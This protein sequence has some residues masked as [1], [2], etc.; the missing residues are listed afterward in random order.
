MAD[1][2][3]FKKANGYHDANAIIAMHISLPLPFYSTGC[4]FR[5]KMFCQLHV[6]TFC[7]IIL[8]F[9]GRFSRRFNVCNKKTFDV[10]I[11]LKI[12]SYCINKRVEITWDLINPKGKGHFTSLGVL[13]SIKIT[14]N[15]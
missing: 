7:G 6:K 12:I 14:L 15:L 3:H 10:Q 1:H 2:L 4:N 13:L 9:I 5:Y 8:S 11:L